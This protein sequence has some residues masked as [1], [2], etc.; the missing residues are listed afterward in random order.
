M[1]NSIKPQTEN[2][3]FYVV[4]CF[5]LGFF[6]FYD[7]DIRYIYGYLLLGIVLAVFFV[8]EVLRNGLGLE[9]NNLM[10]EMRR[11]GREKAFNAERRASVFSGFKSGITAAFR[12]RISLLRLL[13]TLFTCA[14]VFFALL[15]NSN[16]E[17]EAMSIMISMVIFLIFFLFAEPNKKEVGNILVAVQVMAALF[18]GYI[19]VM[20]MCPSLFYNHVYPYLS[21]LSQDRADELMPLGYGALIGGST[22][23]GIFVISFALF[24]NEFKVLT[25]KIKGVKQFILVVATT[26]LYFTA[27]LLVNRRSELISVLV[28]GFLLLVISLL[29]REKAGGKERILAIGV[30]LV[31]QLLVLVLI[32]PTGYINRHI[33]TINKF[34]PEQLQI[35]ISAEQ[36]TLPD[37]PTDP[38]E[39]NEQEPSEKPDEPIDTNE[40]TSG[41]LALWKKA[42][43]L[44]RE[45]PLFGIGWKQFVNHNTYLHNVHN[46]Y[47][48]WLCE[49]GVVGFL[50]LFPLF[51]AMYIISLIR[52][53]RMM[54][55][56]N[57]L[58][59]Y[60][61]EIAY[62]SLGVQTLFLILHLMDS[63]FYHLYFFIF[64]SFTMLLTETALRFED[65]YTGEDSDCLRRKLFSKKKTRMFLR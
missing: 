4:G 14:I 42:I 47:L 11:A 35:G 37:Q 48:Q 41:R 21:E 61:Q 17:H 3:L 63:T 65:G 52:T 1:K 49:S 33:N 12:I 18:A 2:H 43:E 7:L 34:L 29:H 39:P 36:P 22:S 59:Q 20:T 16:K 13:Y 31:V 51:A 64:Y 6:L 25:G 28:A 40:L 24:L 32:A 27:S 58:P 62:I 15:P 30:I 54:R 38:T 8:R 55:K 57:K 10:Q 46:T 26:V 19:I 50:I 60:I 45:K 53:M 5:L 9:L 44:F 23:Y 56:G